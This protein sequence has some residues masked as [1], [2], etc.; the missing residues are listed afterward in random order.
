[1][2]LWLSAVLWDEKLS[3]DMEQKELLKIV[4]EYNLGGLE[5]RPYWKA[6]SIQEAS[7]LYELGAAMGIEF[8]YACNDAIIGDS[9][10]KSQE[11]FAGIRKSIEIAKILRSKVIRVNIGLDTDWSLLDNP[12]WRKGANEIIEEAV[13]AGIVLAVE[14]P[15]RRQ[16]GNIKMV[17][18]LLKAL[19]NLMLTF[20]TGN[21]VISGEHPT[22]AANLFRGRI[23]YLHLKD[24]RVMGAGGYSHCQPG[25]GGLDFHPLL[26]LIYGQ[27]YHGPA[28]LEFAAGD[29]GEEQTKKAIGYLLK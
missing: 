22:D 16:D 2:S 23:G 13:E 28:V 15:P 5:V 1:M 21:W 19:P 24:V 27:G 14:N 6:D 12:V 4:K 26:D 3:K 10:V 18:E 9:L 25:S 7:K 11:G 20:D 29:Q 17:E 8:T